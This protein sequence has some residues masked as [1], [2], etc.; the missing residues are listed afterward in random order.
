MALEFHGNE[1]RIFFKYLD[2]MS[3]HCH[4]FYWYA[5]MNMYEEVTVF[6]VTGVCKQSDD[7]R[8]AELEQKCSLP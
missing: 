2:T 7:I 5:P 1:Y 8:T 4:M 6:C 3:V